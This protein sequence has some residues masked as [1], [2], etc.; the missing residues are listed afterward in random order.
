[1]TSAISSQRP[2]RKTLLRQ[3]TGFTLIELLVVIAIIA[4]LA[5]M[6]LPALS[7]AKQR[8]QTIACISNLKQL[9]LG[10][11]MYAGDN[12]DSVMDNS[13][14]GTTVAWINETTGWVNTSTGATNIL[15]LQQGLLFAY[16]SNP[17]VYAC[18]AASSPRLVRNYSIE[19]RMN[20]DQ[21]YVLG[22]QYPA[23]SKMNQIISPAPVNAM[24]FVDESI[25]TIDDGYFAMQ[26]GT[27]EWQNSPTVRHAKG[28]TFA[29]ADG[30][31]ERWGWKVLNSE[32][33][34]DASTGN[35]LAD[36]VRVQNA[37]FTP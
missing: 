36:M 15:A 16:V 20:G 31:S 21:E 6:L 37:I 13:L 1:M 14:S 2:A 33:H 9:G 3:R 4:I 10:W 30:H 19:G 23:Y 24:V 11:I 22:P 18:P 7:R 17:G 26:S 25:N 8:A 12:G 5:A 27:T 34:G 28:G 32:Q 29:F 35:T